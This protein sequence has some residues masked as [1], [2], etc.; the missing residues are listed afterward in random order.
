MVFYR[1]YRP[2]TIDQLDNETVRATLSS[3]L[4]APEI[5]H[6]FLF[7]GSKGLGKTSAARII[8]KAL[9]CERLGS[10]KLASS[11]KNE[12]N[13]KH[14]DQLNADI[15]PCN[16]CEMCRS[17]TSGTNLDVL[18]IDAA[19]NRGIDEIRDLRDKVRLAP[20]S[21]DKKVYIIDEVHMLTT[22]AFNALL[23]TLEEPPSHVVFILATTEPQK[24]PDTILSRCLHIWFHKATDRELVRSFKRIVKGEG[25]VADD[26]ALLAIA[27]LSDG[28][29]RDGVKILEELSLLATDK[30]ITREL[31]E[32]KYQITSIHSQVTKMLIMLTKKDAKECFALIA[33]L[34]EQGVDMSYFITQLIEGLHEVLL[35]KVGVRESS[36]IN[37]QSLELPFED[38]QILF[39]LLR[40]AISQMKQTVISELPLELA[41]VSYTYGQQEQFKS[42]VASQIPDEE[43]TMRRD[44]TRD[45]SDLRKQVG[46]MRKQDALVSQTPKEKPV[47][48][49]ESVNNSADLLSHDGSGKVTSVWLADFWKAFIVKVREHNHTISGVLRGCSLTSFDKKVL[50]ISTAY[51]FHK[52]RLSEPRT[53]LA[54]E[55][56]AGDLTG[57]PVTVRIEL[58]K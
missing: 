8:A 14:A 20:V 37:I 2:Q 4:S 30:K 39:S 23:K 33:T 54:L 12:L 3:V 16:E 6:A 34:T 27:K 31:V 47:A 10:S 24:I 48:K 19:S 15:E 49:I 43:I 25:L 35:A 40:E 42:S 17:I 58:K 53:L 51:V 22:E 9:N 5:P 57:N 26:E 56:A 18:E 55:K 46:H 29:F 32:K 41:I 36:E 50:I 38:L 52:D 28:G 1:K 45:L 21:A 44:T 7:T 13:P 11:S